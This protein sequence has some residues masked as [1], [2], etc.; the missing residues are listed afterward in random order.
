MRI[1]SGLNT[2][3]RLLVLIIG[4]SALFFIL[5]A[6]LYFYTLKQEKAVYKTASMEYQNAVNSIFKLNSKTHT[7]SIVDVTFWD[8]MVDFIKTKDKQWYKDYIESEFLTY[9]ADY[10]GIYDLNKQCLSKTSSP[11]LTTTDFISDEA[12]EQLY[13]DKLTRFYIKIPEGIIEVFGATIHPSDDPKKNKHK[14]S[15]YF[16]MARLLNKDFIKKLEAIS[17]SVITLVSKDYLQ[18]KDAN[19]ISVNIDLNNWKN[20]NIADLHFKRA[21]NL[22]FSNTK[23]ILDIIIIATI[24][25]LLIYLYY[26]RRW[27]YKPVKL[28]TNILEKKD[29]KS[30]SN[31]KKARNEFGHIGNLFEENNNQRKQLIIAKEK[32]E[33]SDKLKSSFLANLSHEI[34]TP[35]NA[36]IGFSDLLK[37]ESLNEKEKANYLKIIRNSGKN[38]IGI[39]EDLIEMSKIDSNQITPNYKFINLDKCISELYQSIKISIPEEKK[40]AFSVH[41][42]HEFLKKNVFTDE[43]KLKQIL[44]NLITNAIKFTK[45]GH[46]TI[47]Y[48]IIESEEKIK[49]WVD[50][51]GLGIDEENQKIIFDRFRRIED[52]FTMKLSGLGLGLSITKAYVELLGGTISVKSSPGTGSIFSFTIPLKYEERIDEPITVDDDHKTSV[53]GH[54]TILIAEDDDI[55]FLLLEKILRLKDYTVLRA[56]NGK[57]AVELFEAN[58]QID[59]IFMDI[60]M[61]IMNGFEAFEIIRKSNSS[62]PI[63]AN[64]A[65][66]SSEDKEQIK[67]AGFTDY[68]SKPLNKD[69][70]HQ[71]LLLYFNFDD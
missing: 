46:V 28:I 69:E 1:L 68:I 12:F 34:R 17:S 63:I 30:I 47:G 56:T 32:A 51:S 59:L 20:E 5:Y 18:E 14:P 8:E 10:I 16:I 11:I 36:I 66:S 3:Y 7:A 67:R 49:I 15:G 62:V 70:I 61:P 25:N 53:E 37:D 4:T 23:K 39:I 35:M 19:L 58:S 52:D 40:V 2:Y 21:F 64:T 45:K 57:E 65:Y 27:V 26:Y 33:E 42:N 44:T 43:I 38:L 13:K 24:I 55:N 50:D 22:N 31:L 41:K 6:S 60:K 71:L 29:E 54:K 48:T 9:E